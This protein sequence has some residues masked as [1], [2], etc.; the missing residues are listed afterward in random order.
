MTEN[1]AR[2]RDDRPRE[3]RGE[4]AAELDGEPHVPGEK[5]RDAARQLLEVAARHPQIF[6]AHY[7]VDEADGEVESE[8]IFQQTGKT[9][10]RLVGGD[11]RTL[12]EP[13]AHGVDGLIG[14][15]GGIHGG[16][17]TG[18]GHGKA[19]AH[20]GQGHSHCPPP[21]AAEC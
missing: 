1:A 16:A 3:E 17:L 21:D 13:P 7:A 12:R 10:G 9:F 20:R 19:F 2:D 5:L 6:G 18:N 8:R 4:T 11:I 14:E 15:V